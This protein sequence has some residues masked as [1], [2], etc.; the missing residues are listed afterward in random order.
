MDPFFWSKTIFRN[1]A[2]ETGEYPTL[3]L[4]LC[5]Y[6]PKLIFL[7]TL[8]QLCVRTFSLITFVDTNIIV[9]LT[10][11]FEKLVA[12]VRIF[13]KYFFNNKNIKVDN[14]YLRIG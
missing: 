3:Y 9:L 2:G 1:V 13:Q 6:K 7:Y 5:K 12:K 8:F 10:L 11:T 14:T 4:I